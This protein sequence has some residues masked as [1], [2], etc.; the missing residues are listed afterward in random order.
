MDDGGKSILPSFVAYAITFGAMKGK[1][2]EASPNLMVCEPG[3]MIKQSDPRS[4]RFKNESKAASSFSS[5]Y[6]MADILK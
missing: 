5:S 1:D 2:W 4:V 6:G 3:C